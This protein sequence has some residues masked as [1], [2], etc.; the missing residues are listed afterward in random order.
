MG[1]CKW[2]ILAAYERLT[3]GLFFVCV[4]LATLVSSDEMKKVFD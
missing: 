4:L 2:I 1:I 3:D